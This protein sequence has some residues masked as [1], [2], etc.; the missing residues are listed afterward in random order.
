MV[1]GGG[2]GGLCAAR[3]LAEHGADVVV[4][5]QDEVTAESLQRRG[6]PQAQ[7][8]HA[9]LARGLRELEALFPGL[10]D[11]LTAVGAPEADFGEV[12]RYRVPAGW[13]PRVPVGLPIRT[14]TRPVLE[15]L[16]R[17]RVLADPRVTTRGGFTAEDLLWRGD[18][19]CGV[20]GP[21]V[22]DA[23]LV[24]VATGRHSRV[25]TWL[26]YGGFEPPKALV[27]D[28]GTVYT[29]REFSAGSTRDWT[30]VA[31]FPR[32]PGVRRGG[33]VVTTES[34][35]RLVTLVGADGQ[36][37]PT[38]ES[39]FLN[40]ARGLRAPE[41]ADVIGSGEP[42]GTVHRMA[43]LHSRWTLLH[44]M[45]RWPAGLLC[46]GD[47]VCAL[48][49]VHAQG[50]T[51]AAVQAAVLRDGL[52]EGVAEV[53][54]QRRIAGAVG[55]AWALATGADR[56]WDPFPTPWRSRALVRVLARVDER[57]PGDPG[58]F[59]DFSRVAH[60]VDRPGPG[61]LWRALRPVR[62]G[63]Q[64]GAVLDQPLA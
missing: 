50:M 1:V 3:V 43:R 5:E 21:R 15:R 8:P 63:H 60:L 45:P 62:R 38:T 49:P 48:N 12:V 58:L 22:V 53:E 7:H 28:A 34:G 17:R 42:V 57:L 41:F 29:T 55:Q 54:L 47:A 20:R 59:R 26:R 51:V 25:G 37:A 19:V 18:R 36:V 61:L 32:A 24:V 40:Y 6:V 39:G 52:A 10:G 44:R 35:T 64:R 9:L 46:L 16:L 14:V 33:L 27:V 31:E 11:E 13:A 2:F 30:A 23:D 56:V 4:L